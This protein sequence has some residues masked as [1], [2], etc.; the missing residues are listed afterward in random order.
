MSFEDID[1]LEARDG[2]GN[3]LALVP[4]NQLPPAAIGLLAAFEA[5][6]RQSFGRLGDGMKFFTF[7]AGAVPACEKG[8]I[9]IPYAGETYTWETPFPGCPQK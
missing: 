3:P 1:T 4:R 2:G 7:D 5:A 8:G 9:S 6:F